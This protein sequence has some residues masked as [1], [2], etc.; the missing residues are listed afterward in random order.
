[1]KNRLK[2]EILRLKESQE[3]TMTDIFQFE[4]NVRGKLILKVLVSHLDLL[5][6]HASYV[7]YMVHKYN[8]SFRYSGDLNNQDVLNKINEEPIFFTCDL[9]SKFEQDLLEFYINR[10]SEKLIS[11]M[12]TSRTSSKFANL[13]FEWEIECEQ[14]L[15][16]LYREILTEL[17]NK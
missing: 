10:S 6:T 8:S 13:V 17:K 3:E 12:I 2:K 1:M 11:G 5:E 4:N 7:G 15:I 16:R 9:Y 14:Y